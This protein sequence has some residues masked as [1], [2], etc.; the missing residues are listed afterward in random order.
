MVLATIH[1]AAILRA[2]QLCKRSDML[3]PRLAR[4][5]THSFPLKALPGACDPQQYRGV[6]TDAQRRRDTLTHTS[7]LGPV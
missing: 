3:W 4:D 6:T 5:W 1:H 7:T 2:F